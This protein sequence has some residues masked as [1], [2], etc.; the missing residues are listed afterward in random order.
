[1]SRII[2]IAPSILNFDFAR[3][4]E[5]VKIVE[6]AGADMLHIDVIDGVF[7]PN[8]SIGPMVVKSLRKETNIFF[9]VHLMIVN[10][11]KYID[12]FIDAGADSITVSCESTNH[13]YRSIQMIKNRGIKASVALNPATPLC[14]LDNIY[15]EL[16]MILIMTVNPGFGGQ[17]YIESCTEKIRD[18]RKALDARERKIDLEVDGGIGL[19]TIFKT[20]DAGANVFVAGTAISQ[21]GNPKEMLV[22]LREIANSALR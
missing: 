1:M 2:K 16:D 18:L 11:E 4:A 17:K 10:P 22:K 9:D 8:I 3:L 19:D 15:D 7:A 20:A 13:L 12:N 21:S 6:D 5:K 14:F